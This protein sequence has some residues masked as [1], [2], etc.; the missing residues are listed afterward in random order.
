MSQSISILEMIIVRLYI[1]Q[2]AVTHSE[3]ISAT[4]SMRAIDSTQTLISNTELEVKPR[5]RNTQNNALAATV[6]RISAASLSE[7]VQFTVDGAVSYEIVFG[8]F[9]TRKRSR[10]R[11]AQITDPEVRVFLLLAAPSQSQLPTHGVTKVDCSGDQIC[12][13]VAIADDKWRFEFKRDAVGH[14]LNCVR[15]A[16]SSGSYSDS[17]CTVYEIDSPVL[18]PPT[19]GPISAAP[20]ANNSPQQFSPGTQNI[21]AA[22]STVLSAVVLLVALLGVF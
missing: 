15:G 19:N 14:Y 8:K 6:T 3:S 21:S 4:C 10:A 20:A 5:C 11:G 1:I 7:S 18:T 9:D 17:T 16:D 2:W 22:T 13:E 12:F